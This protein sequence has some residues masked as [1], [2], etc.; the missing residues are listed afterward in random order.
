MS[1]PSYFRCELPAGASGPWVVEKVVLPDRDVPRPIDPRP[2]CFHFRPGTYT[3][4]RRESTQFMTDLYDE[5]WTQRRVIEETRRRGGD[6]LLTGLGLGLIAEAVL[7]DEEARVGRITIVELSE[8]VVRLVGPWLQAR[9]P[10]RIEIAHADAF[11]WEPP[12]GR[13]FTVGWHDIWPDPRA[14]TNRDEIERLRQ[15]HGRWCD[16]QGFWPEEYLAAAGEAR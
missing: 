8:D 7:R 15:H 3:L 9:Y 14:E 2:E 10:G 16:W 13:R 1:A 11:T 5:W 12:S 6:V 4:L